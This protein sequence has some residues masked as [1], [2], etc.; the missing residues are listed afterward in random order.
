[1]RFLRLLLVFALLAAS[2]AR[3]ATAPSDGRQLDD[4]ERGIV[5]DPEN[6]ALAADYR[7]LAIQAGAYDRSIKLFERLSKRRDAGANAF[8]NLALAYVDRVPASGAIR[9]V[10][11]GRDAIDALTKSIARQ[12]NDLAYLVRGVINLFF[13]KAIFHRVD[14]GVADLEEA[15]RLSAAHPH[16]AYVVRI[17]TSLGDGYFRLDQPQK[18]REIWRAGQQAFP[19]DEGLRRR[20]NASDADARGIIAHVLDADVRVDTSLRDFLGNT[21]QTIATARE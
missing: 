13:D 5:R 6:L 20:L 17:Y 9:Q 7:Q 21:V 2:A 3:A 19:S 8:M 16:A 15:R 14:K 1:M 18:A 4:L 12:P 10:F 11:L